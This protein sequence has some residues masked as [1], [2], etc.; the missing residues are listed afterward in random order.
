MYS[1]GLLCFIILV[2]LVFEFFIFVKMFFMI[3]YVGEIVF[4][5]LIC[6]YLITILFNPGM[7]IN[8][9]DK[10]IVCNNCNVIKCE[11][12]NVRHCI[13]CDVCIEGYDHHCPLDWE[14]CW[15]V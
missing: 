15:E 6:S 2:N 3:R 9:D 12:S 13:Y 11:T 7:C 8:N 14:M 5:V 10:G 1:L 4:T